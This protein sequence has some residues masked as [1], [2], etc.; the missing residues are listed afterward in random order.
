MGN[1]GLGVLEHEHQEHL[2]IESSGKLW[3]D[4]HLVVDRLGTVADDKE[5]DSDLLDDRLSSTSFDY[6]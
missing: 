4:R 1:C 3:Q 6:H 2:S 5:D